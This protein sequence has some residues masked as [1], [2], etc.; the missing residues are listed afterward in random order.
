MNSVEVSNEFPDEESTCK[1]GDYLPARLVAV[2]N[3]PD[4][5]IKA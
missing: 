2:R 5:A 4:T 1:G 3:D